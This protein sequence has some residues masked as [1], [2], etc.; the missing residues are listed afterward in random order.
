MFDYRRYSGL[1]RGREC[2]KFE[3]KWVGLQAVRIASCSTTNWRIGHDSPTGA[4]KESECE[5]DTES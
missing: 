3:D 2:N 5:T 4:L 1:E